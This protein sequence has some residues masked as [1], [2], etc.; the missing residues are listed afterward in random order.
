M[1]AYLQK[2]SDSFVIIFSQ[3]QMP[4][5]Y[6]NKLKSN[7]CDNGTFVPSIEAKTEYSQSSSITDLYCPSLQYFALK[8]QDGFSLEA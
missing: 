5:I 8:H 7:I 4:A 3:G 6:T 2:E 1:A